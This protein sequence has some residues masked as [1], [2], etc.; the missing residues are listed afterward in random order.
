MLWILLTLYVVLVVF[1]TRW[2]AFTAHLRTLGDEAALR[3]LWEQSATTTAT[4]NGGLAPHLLLSQL[5]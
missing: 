5:R 2:L 4:N 1:M 3:M